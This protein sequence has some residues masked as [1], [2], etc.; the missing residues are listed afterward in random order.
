MVFPAAI[1]QIPFF[2]E[3]YPAAVNFGGLGSVM[4]HELSHGK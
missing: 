1:L 3:S 4:G 2:S